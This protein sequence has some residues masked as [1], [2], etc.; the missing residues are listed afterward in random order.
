MTVRVSKH[1]F[2]KR[3]KKIFAFLRDSATEQDDLGLEYIDII[4]YAFSEIL[5]ISVYNVGTGFI[6]GT[7]GIEGRFCVYLVDVT[8]AELAYQRVPRRCRE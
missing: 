5:N 8:A 6:S 7:F 2:A 1:I 4:D 3:F